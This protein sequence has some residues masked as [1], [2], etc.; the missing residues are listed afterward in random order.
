MWPATQVHSVWS[1]LRGYRRSEYTS[2]RAVTLLQLMKK[3]NTNHPNIRC[4][5]RWWSD[6][7]V[8]ALASINEANQ[9]G[10]RLVLTWVSV[11]VFNFRCGHL[12][13][14]VT[15]HSGQLSL[16]IPWWVGAMSTSQR[17]VTLC[18][19][20]VKAGMVRVWM[21]GK[22]MW[23]HYYTRAISERFRDKRAC[24][25]ALYKFPKRW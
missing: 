25:K 9:L 15:S 5:H 19:W 16:A 18:G 11:S 20:G 22:T 14:Y 17:A 10:A 6:V 1:S 13:R 23:S 3:I 4:D 8:S 24:N 21:A 12:S 2:Q 7:V